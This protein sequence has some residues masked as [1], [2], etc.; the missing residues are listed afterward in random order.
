M[1]NIL[2]QSNRYEQTNSFARTI[3]SSS[4][5]STCRRCE[6]VTKVVGSFIW[7]KV[8]SNAEIESIE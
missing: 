7:R 2:F 6:G 8:N 5:G 4:D 3:Q 1:C